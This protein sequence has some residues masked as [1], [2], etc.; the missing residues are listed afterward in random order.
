MD[1]VYRDLWLLW[2]EIDVYTLL[3]RVS[4]G[5]RWI[6]CTG[7]CGYFGFRCLHT[8]EKGE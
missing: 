5:K 4:N 1:S 2:V 3:K 7:T 6:V 8:A